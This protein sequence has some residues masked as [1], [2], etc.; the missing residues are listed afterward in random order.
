M[1]EPDGMKNCNTQTLAVANANE[2]CVIQISYALRTRLR[3]G[4]TVL[5]VRGG[6]GGMG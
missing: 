3:D 6:D 1:F 2:P 5:A 4:A